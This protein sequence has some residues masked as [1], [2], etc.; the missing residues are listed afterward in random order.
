MPS[1]T[2]LSAVICCTVAALLPASKS[3]ADTPKRTEPRIVNIYNFCRNTD[4]RIEDSAELL[5]TTAQQIK[6]VHQ[7]HFTGT[8]ALQYDAML[9]PD[10]QKLM[11]TQLTPQDELGGW[12]EIPRQL[13]EKAGLK[14]RGNADWNWDPNC[15]IDYASGYEPDERK[16]MVDVFMAD[17]RSIFGHYPR[18]I[19]AWY[20]DEISLAYM[21]DKYGIVASCNRADRVKPGN[22]LVAPWGGYRDQGYYPSK[23]NAFMPAQTKE[24]QVNVPIF[25]MQGNDPIY[26]YGGSVAEYNLEPIFPHAGGSSKWVEWYFR[27]LVE[28][29]CL[30]FRYAQTGQENSFSWDLI[31]QG[32]GFQ[33]STLAGLVKKG[34]VRVETLEKTGEWFKSHF[35]LTP[36]TAAVSLDDWRY[37]G[38]KSVWYNS[39]FYRVNFFW[40][41]GTVVLRDLHLFDERDVSPAYRGVFKTSGLKVETLPVVEGS[42]WGTRAEPAN[43]IFKLGDGT[44][45]E[46]A[47][48]PTV[49]PSG[50]AELK[51]L[52]PL[53]GGGELTVICGESQ[54]GCAVVD[55]RHQPIAWA[56]E[57]HGGTAQAK[58]LTGVS[59]HQLQ[60][61]SGDFAYSLS[62]QEGLFKQGSDELMVN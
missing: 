55:A 35:E 22:N 50:T 10:Y 52:Q 60:F 30:G 27:S 11:K 24:A 47:G 31:K 18:T 17:F 26:Q 48:D 7:N 4:F 28:Q 38:R 2:I 25:R 43:A 20:I 33:L 36:A 14:W 54:V 57:L 42:V 34:E 29:P 15:R 44:P 41:K 32:M 62:V 8:W 61:K 1:K 23:F 3:T 59:D 45:L 49:V 39:R 21:G 19:G 53:K 16:K 58:A 37:Q 13:V 9:N 6:L 56:L 51:I 40:D 12:W 46:I 5:K